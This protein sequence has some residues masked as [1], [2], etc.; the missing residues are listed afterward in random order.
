M[1]KRMEMKEHIQPAVRKQARLEPKQV[2][3]TAAWFA[4]PTPSQPLKPT[5]PVPVLLPLWVKQPLS[6]LLPL[7]EWKGYSSL[8]ACL[9][10]QWMHVYWF[11]FARR[12]RGKGRGRGEEKENSTVAHSLTSW[13]PRGHVQS[14]AENF[15][16]S[17]SFLPPNP[18]Q[19]LQDTSSWQG[20]INPGP[21]AP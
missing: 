15:S 7:L 21:S 6:T 14:G 2:P 8:L 18:G 11:A 3:T 20:F 12:K 10:R 4:P 13:L 1:V 16:Y 5:L 9:L 17:P 19:P